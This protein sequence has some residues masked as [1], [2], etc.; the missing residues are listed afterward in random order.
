M[1]TDGLAFCILTKRLLLLILFAD[2]MATHCQMS[3]YICTAKMKTPEMDCC[4][5]P[6]VHT[7]IF[8]NKLSISR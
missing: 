3:E 8:F 6:V 7:F 2:R 1:Q 5:L 4:L